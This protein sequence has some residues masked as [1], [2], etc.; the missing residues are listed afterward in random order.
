MLDNLTIKEVRQTGIGPYGFLELVV[1][2]CYKNKKLIKEIESNSS[3][4]I[5]YFEE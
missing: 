1:Y 5:N 4:S 2:R 3:L